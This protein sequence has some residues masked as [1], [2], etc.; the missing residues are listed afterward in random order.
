LKSTCAE[1]AGTV[2]AAKALFARELVVQQAY[3]AMGGLQHELD[4]IVNWPLR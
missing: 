2:D 4:A 1:S 3:Y